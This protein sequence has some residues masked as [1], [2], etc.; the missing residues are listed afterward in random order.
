LAAQKKRDTFA[1]AYRGVW[2]TLGTEWKKLTLN[3][4]TLA[5]PVYPISNRQTFDK[6][7]YR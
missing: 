2:Q 1:S 6:A 4:V 3:G 7:E 5:I